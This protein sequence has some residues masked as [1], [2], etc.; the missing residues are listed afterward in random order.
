MFPRL[1]VVQ[2]RGHI[3]R[4]TF[5]NTALIIAL[6][7]LYVFL[8]QV[9]ATAHGYLR[10]Y[11]H[12]PTDFEA[13]VFADHWRI[14]ALAA[15]FTFVVVEIQGFVLR[16]NQ[17]KP[18]INPSFQ[19]MIADL[20][21]KARLTYTPAII[22]LPEGP[23]NAAA[24][25]ST[26]FGGKVLV[27]GDILQRLDEREARA[28]FAHEI[29]HLVN[30]DIWAMLLLRIGSGGLAWQKWGLLVA[31]IIAG[32]DY[33]L[34]TVRTLQ[35]GSPR[36][37]LFLLVALAITWMMHTVYKLGE[38]AHSRGREYLADAGAIA[39]TG[40]G[41]RPQLISALLKVGHGQTGWSPFRLLRRTG[42]EIFM[43]HP[44]IADRAAVLHIGVSEAPA[45]V[46]IGEVPDSGAAPA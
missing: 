26:F 21:Q 29:A 24:T 33:I 9:V 28:V 22:Y 34:Q 6:P 15:L 14:M 5:R 42:G 36:D 18:F 16:R 35:L 45:G 2:L 13:Q 40:W 3:L 4:T 10:G 46:R 27:M 1:W 11:G 8:P 38:M 41:Q 43:P 12:V 17:A 30:R 31:T 7:L 37:L 32:Q 25:K 20:A 19:A 44:P 23:V 39:L